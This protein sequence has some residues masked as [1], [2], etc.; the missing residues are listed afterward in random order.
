M[1][2]T[3]FGSGADL[4]GQTEEPLE[5][6]ELVGALIGQHAAA[7]AAPA[8]APVARIVVILGTEPVGDG[9]ADPAELTQFA[10][11]DQLLDLDV[12]RQ[13][14]LVEHQRFHQIGVFFRFFEQA[15]AFS[16]VNRQRFFHNDVFARLHGFN[17]QIGVG[18]VGHCHKHHVHFGIVD[19]FSGV[20]VAFDLGAN[21]RRDAVKRFGVDVANR[22]QGAAPA[23]VG[24]INVGTAHIADTDNTETDFLFRHF[25]LLIHI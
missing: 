21:L 10:G 23:F 5:K 3:Q 18:I 15:F 2:F 11:V 13:S 20:I 9:P 1:I 14:T 8:G 6:V 25:M 12:G 22:S 16:F 19:K 24:K 17:S 4:A 7:F